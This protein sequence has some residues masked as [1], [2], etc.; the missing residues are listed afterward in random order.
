[1]DNNRDV[2][3][4]VNIHGQSARTRVLRIGEQKVLGNLNVYK[5]D[6]RTVKYSSTC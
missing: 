2:S 1:M 4:I 6:R 5:N 3:N